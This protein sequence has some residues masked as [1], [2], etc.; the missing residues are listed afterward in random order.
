M[1]ERLESAFSALV[2]GPAPEASS[3]AELGRWLEAHGI[4]REDAEVMLA[5]GVERLLLYRK[6]VRHTLEETLELAIPRAMA[7]L[8]PLFEEYFNRF[9]A[10]AGPRSHYLRDVTA[11]FLD[12]AEPLWKRDDRVSP[13]IAELARHEALRIEIGSMPSPRRVENDAPL[14]LESGV[15]FSE[16]TRLVRYRHAVHELSDD[17]TDRQTPRF[18]ETRLFVYRS[19]EHEV[20]YLE[21]TS[22]AAAIVERL[23]AGR[24][25]GDAIQAACAE[26]ASGLDPGVLDG[27]ARLLADLAE[28][29]ALVG[30]ASK[31]AQEDHLSTQSRL[32]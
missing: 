12:F 18:R 29:G 27:A 1:Q 4:P 28:R 24:A 31:P 22:L 8:G 17:P 26:E 9:L 13:Y 20:R 21:L 25:L 3:P 11:E 16:A 19:P 32:T 23:L 2:L 7:R 6:L 30:K 10:D 14:E 15:E 5:A